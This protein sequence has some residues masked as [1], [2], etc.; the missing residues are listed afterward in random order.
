MPKLHFD[1]KGDKEMDSLLR[2]AGEITG[3]FQKPLERAGIYMLRQTDKRF[4][5][6]VSPD[7]KPWKKHSKYSPVKRP[8]GRKRSS[9]PQ[10][11]QAHK[12]LLGRGTLRNS[13]SPSRG[14]GAVWRMSK[15]S[16]DLG[17]N[18]IYANVH[19][20]GAEIVPVRK[21]W[22]H[23][24]DG[25]GND[26]FSK[27]VKIPARP[28]LGFSKEDIRDVRGIFVTWAAAELKK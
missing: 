16:L 14:K 17:T 8:K 13:V 15:K 6:Q 27:R 21:K 25:A 12:I 2:R 26:H 19:Q 4:Q 23:W 5:Q 9:L 20:F 7:G 18:L 1:L 11:Q 3:S 10:E 24:L 22:L 28:F